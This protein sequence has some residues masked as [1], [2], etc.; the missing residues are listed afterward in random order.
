MWRERGRTLKFC[1]IG[2]KLLINLPII[3]SKKYIRHKLDLKWR[4]HSFSWITHE[5]TRSNERE[6]LRTEKKLITT[7]TFLEND[8][9]FV[10]LSFEG[11]KY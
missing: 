9:P 10:L 11:K 8:W 3:L 5:L 2:H 7:P 4:H 1:K 6:K